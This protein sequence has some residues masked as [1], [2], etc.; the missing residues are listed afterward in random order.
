MDARE[1]LRTDVIVMT[2]VIYAGI[3]VLADAFARGLERWLLRW[4]PNYAQ[5]GKR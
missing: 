3:G 1:F 2:I 5:G 4:H